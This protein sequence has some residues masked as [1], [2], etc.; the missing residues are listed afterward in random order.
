MRDKKIFSEFLSQASLV[1][2]D[3]GRKEDFYTFKEQLQN[4]I[5]LYHQW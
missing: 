3:L 1:S 2:S 5:L 4:E